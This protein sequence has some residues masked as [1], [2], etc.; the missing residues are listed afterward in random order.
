MRRVS[1]WTLTRQKK[2]V[3]SHRFLVPI[4]TANLKHRKTGRSM[5]SKGGVNR[6]LG[7]RSG[8]AMT[9]QPPTQSLS[10]PTSSHAGPPQATCINRGRYKKPMRN[11][12]HH[13]TLTLVT[14]FCHIPWAPP[15]ESLIPWGLPPRDLPGMTEQPVT[16]LW[17]FC[18]LINTLNTRF[19]ALWQHTN[20]LLFVFFCQ[21]SDVPTG[22]SPQHDC[23]R[24]KK[25]KLHQKIVREGYTS[26]N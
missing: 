19:F 13:S 23:K 4:H 15:T 24:K 7:P 9:F 2:L 10:P 5:C 11:H 20:L 17:Q 22:S 8:G 16:W 12:P 3:R 18:Y 25:L 14:S 21:F 1:I 26:K 6:G